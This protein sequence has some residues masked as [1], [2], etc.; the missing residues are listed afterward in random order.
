MSFAA[1]LASHDEGALAALASAGLVKRARRDLE[2]GRASIVS[3]EGEAATVEADGH[4]VTLGPAGVMPGAC[5]CPATGVC[6]HLVLAILALRADGPAAS[7]P[8]SA[9]DAV[10]ALPDEALRSFA[11]ADWAGALR[12]AHASVDAM[13][14]KVDGIL[15][16]Q[17]PDAPRPVSFLP[18]QELTATVYKGPP[19]TR[20]RIIAAAALVARDR[21]GRTPIPD[22]EVEK[23]VAVL[24]V[25]TLRE[26]RAAIASLVQ[27]L[28]NGGAMLVEE[29]LFDLSVSAQAEA[30]PR[31]SGLLRTL[32]RGARAMRARDVAYR[33]VDLL[34]IA[35]ETYALTR[36]LESDPFDPGLT[37]TI[38]RRYRETGPRT[39]L[40]LG[41]A[42]WS[43]PS[44][45][46]GLRVHCHDMQAG[47]WHETGQARGAGA[48]RLF[49]PQ[50][51]Y[52]TTLW[53]LAPPAQL[54]GQAL[55]MIGGRMAR[56]GAIA[57]DGGRAEFLPTPPLAGLAHADWKAARQ[58]I[59][60]RAGLGVRRGARPVP[61]L[62]APAE[63]GRP[64][65]DDIAQVWRVS[66]RDWVGAWI[67]LCLPTDDGEPAVWLADAVRGRPL[68]LCEA[69]WTTSE[70]RFVPVTVLAADVAVDLCDSNTSGTPR[71]SVSRP[72]ETPHM[73]RDG[74]TD[75]VRAVAL[76]ALEAVTEAV[77]TQD[78]SQL[79]AIAERSDRIGLRVLADGLGTLQQ[80]GDPDQILKAVYLAWMFATAR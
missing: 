46:R 1:M 80:G 22:L 19:S 9:A 13:L 44:G 42:I 31:L 11:G 32:S 58:D 76:A 8:P 40:V 66:V 73:P 2:A 69:S 60:T 61:V 59:A 17:L 67:D 43:T 38:K 45:A 77:L 12:Q 33:D 3:W 18:G 39:L 20:R 36:A 28:P 48:E 65:F 30:A 74:T 41:T 53:G 10:A 6:R 34:A 29:T 15:R 5:T 52:R 35:A 72:V 50:A 26:I 14:E 63:G 54:A 7:P 16:V 55:R 24:N 37:G 56:D 47:S 62:L 49:S 64:R 25:E 70:L 75:P 78:R 23:T 21:L 71:G 51:A 79:P 57:W 27:S 68:L 4:T